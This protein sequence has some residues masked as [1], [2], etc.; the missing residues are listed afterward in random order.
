MESGN[1]SIK[2]IYSEEDYNYI[3]D[4]AVSWY[5]KSL[6]LPQIKLQSAINPLRD[7]EF[8]TLNYLQPLDKFFFISDIRADIINKRI[9]SRT[10]IFFVSATIEGRL[11]LQF[12]NIPTKPTNNLLNTMNNYDIS[13]GITSNLLT[14]LENIKSLFLDTGFS[15]RIIHFVPEQNPDLGGRVI[16]NFS[17]ASE[18]DFNKVVLTICYENYH[19]GSEPRFVRFNK[20]EKPKK[21]FKC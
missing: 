5:R 2:S 8:F 7:T 18:F 17:Y 11:S 19:N 16:L 9:L 14:E 12:S 15:V 3:L 1:S 20:N 6:L 10:T 13:K 4:K 21:L